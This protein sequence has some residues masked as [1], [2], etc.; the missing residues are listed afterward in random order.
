MWEI[1]LDNYRSIYYVPHSADLTCI[2]GDSPIEA[3]MQIQVTYDILS[4]I[5]INILTNW[6]ND[7]C[8]IW[9]LFSNISSPWKFTKS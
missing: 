6:P 1:L 8:N 5:L 9:P 3:N 2:L 4:N 7:I